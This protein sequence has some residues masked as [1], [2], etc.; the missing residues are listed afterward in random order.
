MSS[1]KQVAIRGMVWTIASY[2]A[3]QMLRF[4]S[5][6]ILSRVLFP[7]VFGLMA[8][9]YVF[10]T[11]LNLFSDLGIAPS[12]VQSKRGDDPKF[13]NTA[14]TLQILR[15]FVIWMGS[16]VLAWPVAQFYAEPRLTWLLPIVGFSGFL[17]FC[18]STSLITLNR[19]M[20]F[21]HLTIF[22]LVMQ[23]VSAAV[24]TV[25]ALIHPSI[26]ALV[27]GNLVWSVLQ[28]VSSHILGA[29]LH[30]PGMPNRLTWD[31]ESLKEL[32]SFGRWIFFSTATTFLASQADRLILGKLFSFSLLGVYGI[33][34]AL[35][36]IPRQ[37]LLVLSE[38]V[39]FPAM[40]RVAD[41]PRAE[42]R[43]KIRRNRDPILL[44][45]A[46]G[47][48][49]LATTGDLLIR[50][51]Y[52]DR[53]QEAA[54]MLPILAVGIWANVLS[55]TID[56]ALFS[57]GKPSYI[58]IA[59]LVRCIFIVVSL[60][61]GFYWLGVPGAVIAIALNDVPF[62][63]GVVYGLIREKLYVPLQDTMA[64]L[65]MMVCLGLAVLVRFSLGFGLPID[66]LFR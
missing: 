53:Y 46:V 33:A 64:T 38:K 54:W 52:D 60:P 12:I 47:V 63:I 21:A 24:V 45:S 13:L 22:N 18:N 37:V 39:F 50:W 58:G 61:L 19:Q 36:E 35:S 7:E 1:L 49:L 8:L 40:S 6:L 29:R 25:W 43:E 15:G 11:G 20:A 17:G 42:F 2:G 34:F 41:L 10:I 44:L 4:A 59:N 30:L 66:D 9:V 5:N 27:G 14:W 48:T 16:F 23:V 57:I 32:F 62:Y 65:F 28:L 31:R 55:Q 56:S 51:L 26:W 3:G